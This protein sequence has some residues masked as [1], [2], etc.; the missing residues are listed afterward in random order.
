MQ[1]LPIEW[2]EA[3]VFEDQVPVGVGDPGTG[4][5][6]VEDVAHRGLDVQDDQR[7]NFSSSGKKRQKF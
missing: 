1:M 2:V 5:Q 6:P 4:G 7:K 3:L